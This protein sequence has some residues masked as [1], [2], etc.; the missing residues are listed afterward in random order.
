[1]VFK[2]CDNV[3]SS[4]EVSAEKPSMFAFASKPA[5]VTRR[6]FFAGKD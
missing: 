4:S 5:S 3:M 2:N 6:F 1:M